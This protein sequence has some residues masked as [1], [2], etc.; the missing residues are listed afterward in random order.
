MDV[1]RQSLLKGGVHPS[2]IGGLVS[3]Y[4][5]LRGFSPMVY[6]VSLWRRSDLYIDDLQGIAGQLRSSGPL[7][8]GR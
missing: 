6:A 3:M 1:V 8:R 2:E 4:S 7:A 5:R